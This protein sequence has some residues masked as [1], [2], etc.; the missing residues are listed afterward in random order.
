MSASHLPALDAI[1]FQLVAALE[2]YEQDA[3]AMID[4]WPELDLYQNVSG[5]VDRIRMYSSALPE[6]RV[7]WVE[8]L[9][10]HAELVHCLWRSTYG[11]PGAEVGEELAEVRERHAESILALRNR[12]L[13][14]ISRGG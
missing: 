10:A 1:A 14:L 7:Q 9:I 13:R 11:E 6:V 8:L 5:Q 3:G 12:C 2:N 4:G